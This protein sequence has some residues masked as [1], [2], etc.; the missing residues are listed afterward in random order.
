M[1]KNGKLFGK[2]SIIDLIVLL[3][4]LVVAVG[5][6]WRFASPAAVL[7]QSNITVDFTIRIDGVRDFTLVN[8]R[9]GLRVYNRQAGQFIGHISGIRYTDHYQPHPLPDGTV[10]S[11]AIPGQITIYMDVTANGRETPTAIYVE[12]THEITAGSLIYLNTKY[13][14][15]SG[16]IHSIDIRR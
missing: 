3:L 10:A 13:V 14:Q 2:I 7:N 6:V 9:E 11:V 16:A 4:V 12:G 1:D 5:S 15:V 8:Y